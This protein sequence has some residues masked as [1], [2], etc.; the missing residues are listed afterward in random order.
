MKQKVTI[1]TYSFIVTIIGIAMLV[2][3]MIFELKRSHEITAYFVAFALVSLCFMALFYS[4]MYISVG[5]GNLNI[6]RSLRIKSIP[7]TD[8]KSVELCAP[9]MSEMRICG[10][11]GWFGYW[12][13]FSEPSIGKYFAYYGK[14]S[15]CFLVRLKD[16]RQYLLS[17]EKPA[18]MVEFL[19]DKITCRE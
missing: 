2:V 9:T 12:G 17:C 16:D 18:Q 10:S 6:H 1:S 5:N 3:M 19:K 14:A 11:G 15:D 4:P 7:I 13:R 8:I